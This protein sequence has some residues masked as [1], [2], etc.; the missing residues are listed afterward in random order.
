MPTYAIG[1]I[2]GCFDALQRLL[3]RVAF[4]PLRDRAWLV[5]DLVRKGPASLDVLRWA[6]A[7]E[8]AVQVVLGNHD[9]HTLACQVGLRGTWQYPELRALFEADDAEDLIAW[10]RTRPLLHLQGDHLLVHAGL[11]PD[12]DLET[13][14]EM[15]QAVEAQLRGP[16]APVLIEAFYQREEHRWDRRLTD[17]E[18]VGLALNCFTRLRTCSADGVPNFRFDGPP[19]SAPADHLPWFE[20]PAPE[21]EGLTVIFG[22]WASLGHRR[23][24]GYCSLDTG[25]TYGGKLSAV[26]LE[27]GRLFQVPAEPD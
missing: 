15:A 12:W 19:E 6:R 1:D 5:G 14:I 2:H 27:D 4:D 20:M 21:R 10:L 11:L 25:C 7:N 23:G 26:R 9:I 24:P 8:A 18:R 13:C 3:G 17:D 16:R 22:H